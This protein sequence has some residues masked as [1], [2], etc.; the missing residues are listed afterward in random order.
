MNL[1]NFLKQPSN[2]LH[3]SRVNVSETCFLDR[4]PRDEHHVRRNIP[5]RFPLSENFP[6]QTLRAISRHGTAD[7]AA[8]DDAYPE[9]ALASLHDEC[10]EETTDDTPTL[11]VRFYELSFLPE[12]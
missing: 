12:T 6:E 2:V 3:V 1:R 7:A 11:L 8:R 4:A 9:R 10:D 5:R